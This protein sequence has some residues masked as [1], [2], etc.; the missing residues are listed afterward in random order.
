MISGDIRWSQRPSGSFPKSVFFAG[1][2]RATLREIMYGP[3]NDGSFDVD[4]RQ[5]TPDPSRRRKQT[6][7]MR[8]HRRHTR[9]PVRISNWKPSKSRQRH[10]AFSLLVLDVH[11]NR[12]TRMADSRRLR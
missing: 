12:L 11:R 7:M 10:E 4:V 3:A 2:V 9:P 5:Q 6:I 1:I 8:G